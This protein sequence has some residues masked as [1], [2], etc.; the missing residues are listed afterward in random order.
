MVANRYSSPSQYDSKTGQMGLWY[1]YTMENLCIRQHDRR[2]NFEFLSD[3][4]K[5]CHLNLYRMT[6][7]PHNLEYS[8]YHP[9]IVFPQVKHAKYQLQYT[10][11][12][13]T[14]NIQVV[15]CG[16]IRPCLLIISKKRAIKSTLFQF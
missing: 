12:E 1:K 15:V 13:T 4:M 16:F 7:V 3:Y 9:R 5:W 14:K 11:C 6:P 10:F 8:N 2:P